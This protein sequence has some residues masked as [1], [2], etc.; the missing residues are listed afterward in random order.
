MIVDVLAATCASRDEKGHLAS[1]EGREC[2][3][4]PRMSDDEVCSNQR[5]VQLVRGQ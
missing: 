1:R 4:Y 3:P 5:F 2:R